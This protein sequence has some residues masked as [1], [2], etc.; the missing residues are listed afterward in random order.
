MT[1]AVEPYAKSFQPGTLGWAAA[2]LEDEEF[3]RAW[4]DGQ[5]EIIEGVLT[6]MP[7]ANFDGNV[8]LSLLRRI[9]ERHLEA[10]GQNPVFTH[11]DDL[12]L[13]E[14]R[15]VRTDMT[16]MSESDRARQREANKARG[17]RRSSKLTYGR[18]LVPPTLI[19]ESVSPGHGTHDRTTK[20]A[21]YAE[22]R[23]PNYWI[24]DRFEKSLECLVLDGKA[25][26]ADSMGRNN[27]EVRPALFAGL[28]IPL[29]QVWGEAADET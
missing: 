10:M 2:D 18:L 5:Y 19:V 14:T 24:L 8:A 26:R 7:P 3:E 17:G 27:D 9:V 1:L 21:W 16:Y 25:Y 11:E 4:N 23:V 15:V 29:K 6:Q 22:A 20:R 28:V 12:I 13:S